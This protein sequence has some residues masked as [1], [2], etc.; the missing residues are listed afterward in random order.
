M[1]K[2]GFIPE[3]HDLDGL[4]TH[5]VEECAEV[6]KVAMKIRRFGWRSYHP[7]DPSRTENRVALYMELADVVFVAD[8][9]RKALREQA[10][11]EQDLQDEPRETPI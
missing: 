6:T 7:D 10:V 11:R 4:L 1:T 5:V 3:E 9:L 2:E 8:R